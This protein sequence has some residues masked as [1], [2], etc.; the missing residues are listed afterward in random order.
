M[1]EEAVGM[2]SAL[3]DLL[4]SLI[5]PHIGHLVLERRTIVRHCRCKADPAGACI[6]LMRGRYVFRN[7]KLS[8]RRM[9]TPIKLNNGCVWAHDS[10]PLQHS[11]ASRVRLDLRFRAGEAT[12]NTA[13]SWPTYIQQQMSA[14]ASGTMPC[15]LNHY[16]HSRESHNGQPFV[17]AYDQG[18]FF[19]RKDEN[20]HQSPIIHVPRVLVGLRT[21]CQ[22]KARS[23][24]IDIQQSMI[25]ISLARSMH[26]DFSVVEEV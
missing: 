4:E 14:C 15:Q 1:C 19:P 13:S 17:F 24:H 26:Q 8:T 22:R 7:I 23:E 16:Q 6:C 20:H 21:S 25:R 2:S 5:T 10:N 9:G 11:K 3:P 12:N 18:Q